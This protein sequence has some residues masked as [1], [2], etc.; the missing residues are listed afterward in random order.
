MFLTLYPKRCAI[1][2]SI[3]AKKENAL[4]CC[5]F[6]SDKLEVIREPVCFKCGKPLDSNEEEYC[7]DCLRVKKSFVSNRAVYE[8]GGDIKDSLMK[9]KY[10]NRQEYANFYAKVMTDKYAD[11][12]ADVDALIPI[13]IHKS[14][15]KE[16]GY[17][18]AE[19][20]ANELSRY[21]GVKVYNDILVRNEKTLAQKSLN[22]LERINNLK[23]AFQLGQNI[24]QLNKVML[25]DDIYTTGATIE[26]CTRLLHSAGYDNI[27]SITVAIGHGY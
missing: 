4:G 16:R 17:N 3:L 11:Y 12:F 27:C 22:D 14:R 6:C 18:Q 19:L 20:I 7:I 24:V 2:D 8:Y 15:L 10:K 25:V 21:C 23:N 13:P 26:A 1:C 9:F 5:D